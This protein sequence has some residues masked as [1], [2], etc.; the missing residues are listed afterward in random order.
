MS[1]F[2]RT[3]LVFTALFTFSSFDVTVEEILGAMRKGDAISISRHF[4]N[5]VEITVNDKTNSY[6]R[7]QAEVVL[8][9]FFSQHNVKSFTINHRVNSSAGEYCVGTLATEGKE[10]RTTIL[11]KMRGDRKLVQE[12]RFE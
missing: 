9:D 2:F 6:S 4:D 3:I 10:Y 7:T 5:L 12:L 1:H 8:R 11:F